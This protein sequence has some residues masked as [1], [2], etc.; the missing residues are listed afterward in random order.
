MTETIV[1][2]N[3]AKRFKRWKQSFT[4]RHFD[5]CGIF[6]PSFPDVWILFSPILGFHS[7]FEPKMI[8]GRASG[9][10]KIPIINQ[11]CLLYPFR[12]AR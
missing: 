10:N 1:L 2:E 4:T 6:I 11:N 5:G 7:I 12:P 9:P 3:I 8:K